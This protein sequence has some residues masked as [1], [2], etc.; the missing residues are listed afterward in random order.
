MLTLPIYSFC[1]LPACTCLKHI[2]ALMK[3]TSRKETTQNEKKKQCCIEREREFQMDFDIKK[4]RKK[5]LYVVY[6]TQESILVSVLS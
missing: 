2:F 6:T 3:T 5:R 1:L 4:E